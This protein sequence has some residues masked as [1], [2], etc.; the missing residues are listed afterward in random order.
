MNYFCDTV[1]SIFMLETSYFLIMWLKKEAKLEL[2][3]TNL[4]LVK[5]V[6]YFLCKR[7]FFNIGTVIAKML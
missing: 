1:K 2:H 4:I 7:G 6:A 3:I 5:I